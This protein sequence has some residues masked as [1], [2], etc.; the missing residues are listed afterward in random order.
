MS[1]SHSDIGRKR[2]RTIYVAGVGGRRPAVPV[3]Q[4]ELE[5]AAQGVMTHEAWAYIAGGAGRES[6]M[7]ANRAAFERWQ[8][9]PRILRDVENRDLSIGLFG[10]RLPSPLLLC[11]IGV[12]ELAHPEAD[13]AVARA[14]AALGVPYIFSNQASVPMETCAAAMGDA[15]RWFQLYWSRSDDLVASFARRAEACGCSAIVLTLD[16][17]M[18]GWRPRDLDR[19]SL[20][21]MRGQGLAQYTSDPVFRAQ[22]AQPMELGDGPK[23]PLNLQAIGT[24]L[25]QKAKFPGGLL[26]NLASG[27]PRTAVQRF[28]ATYSRPSLQWD[29]LKF[30]RQQTKLPILLKG[31]LHPDDARKAVAAGIDGLIV[32]NHGGRQIDGEIAS[33][34]AL[35]A[36][37]EAVNGKIPVLFDSGIRG[38]A[39]VF[40]TLALGAT[41]VC[42]GRPYVYGLALAGQ[43]GVEEVIGNVLAE[44]DLTLGLAGC[45]N[46]SAIGH[47]SIVT[48]EVT[49]PTGM[50]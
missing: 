40:K 22:L 42:L 1:E 11:P 7:D 31:V 6:T 21:F 49:R 41:A 43:R 16:T 36:V 8:I 18:L 25:A 27:E 47:D 2:Q 24:A 46:V 26:K 30:I 33:L 50:E 37:A 15:P 12:L 10:R 13:L 14:A 19:G 44:F 5:K 45:A 3:A 9:V 17:T 38:G 29:G 4:A 34:D 32:S 20:P 48:G 28:M 35:P 39:D 23:P